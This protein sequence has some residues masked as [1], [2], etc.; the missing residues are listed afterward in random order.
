MTWLPYFAYGS[1]LHPLRLRLR[2]CSARKIGRAVLRGYSLRFHKRGLDGSSKCDAV[3][4]GRREDMLQGIVYRVAKRD[5]RALDRAEDL[6]R[7]Y[8]RVRLCVS[9][10]SRRRVVYAYRAR[11]GAIVQGL[12]PFDWY[13]DYVVRGA[14]YH[15]LS[16]R[17][18]R[19]IAGEWVVR[20][21]NAA[22]RTCNLGI[23]SRGGKPLRSR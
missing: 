7:G 5:W 19:T 16:R 6:G 3:L 18:I 1:N 4:T 15:G 22:R 8:E 20:D 21:R 23:S 14:L 17:Y 13:L 12:R 2:A 9:V 11:P 10:G